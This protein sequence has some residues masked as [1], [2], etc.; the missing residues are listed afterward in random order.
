MDDAPYNSAIAEGPA[1]GKAYWV[2]A[3]D[4]V[5]LRV[6]FWE[7]KKSC[8]GTILFFTA[9]SEYLEKYGRTV[10]DFLAFGYAAFAI[11]WR[12]QGLSDRLTDDRKTGHVNR[13]SDYQ[14]DVAAMVKAAKDLNLPE[15]WFLFGNSMGACIGLRALMEG[16]PVTASAFTAPMWNISLS[17]I[18]R[19]VAWPVSWALQTIG[20]GHIY[21]PGRKE[22]SYVLDVPFEDN[23]LTH[24]PDMY[25]YYVDQADQ[26]PETQL[27]SPSMGWLYQSLKECRTLSNLPSPAMPCIAFLGGEDKVVGVGAIKDR[28]A[29]WNGGKLEMV[30][31]GRH[32]LLC[33]IPIIRNSVTNDI[34]QFFS[35]N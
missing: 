19:M 10:S 8:K 21:T 5:R 26:L 9:R 15:P 1:D 25:Q 24:D 31:G 13:F 3:D 2:H 18:E 12:G 28:M 4:G 22:K 11:D 27:G 23:E 17:P 14:R 20:R 16:L 35:T 32:D 7:P 29:G 34:C 30:P 33:E 6:G